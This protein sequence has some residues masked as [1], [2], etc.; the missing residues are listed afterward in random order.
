MLPA[1]IASIEKAFQ[2]I[3]GMC[4]STWEGEYRTVARQALRDVIQ[5]RMRSWVDRALTELQAQ[6]V[7]DR[8]NGTFTRHLLTELGDLELAI[9]RTRTFSA[10]TMLRQVGARLA[11]RAGRVERM[12]LLA[13]TLGLATRKVAKALA[14]VLGEAISPSTVSAVAKQLDVAVAAYH[15]RPLTDRYAVLVLDGVVLKHRTGVGAQRRVTLVALGIL[16]D[17]RREV[18]DF[19]Q[20][21][22]ESRAEWETFLHDLFQ[23]GLTGAVLKLVVAD[24]GAGLWAALPLVY[25]HVPVQRCW[26]HK[27]RNVLDKVRRADQAAVKRALQRISHAATLR[28]A[29]QAAQRFVT[30]WQASYP[31]AIRCLTRDLSELLTFLRVPVGLPA[32][33][34]RTTNAIERR[35]REVKRRTRPMG[36]FSDRTSIDRIL[37]A[38]FTHENSKEGTAT[39]FLLTQ[40]S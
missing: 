17:G 16:P 8:H 30:A 34:V 18:I 5:T 14:P 29:Q 11:R 22:S 31:E 37:F 26:A 6:D 35:F 21:G 20:A 33:A 39:P 1:T 38:V 36:T 27:T 40:N 13:F 19:R 3:K 23:R 12:I 10:V 32:T 15:Q 9:P 2:E 25:P 28:A 4:V 7:A 24:G